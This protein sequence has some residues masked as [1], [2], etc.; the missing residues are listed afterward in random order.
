MIADCGLPIADYPPQSPR[1]RGEDIWGNRVNFSPSPFTGR[2]AV[3]F[4]LAPGPAFFPGYGEGR[5]GVSSRSGVGSF[6]FGDQ[7]ANHAHSHVSINR[8]NE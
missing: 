8:S 4:L 5:G 1:K 6:S 2:A 3:G 7:T